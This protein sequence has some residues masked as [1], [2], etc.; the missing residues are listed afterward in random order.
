[1]AKLLE[2]GF[3][4]TANTEDFFDFNLDIVLEGDE[5]SDILCSFLGITTFNVSF[6]GSAKFDS[7]LALT[8]L[9]KS[10]VD[11]QV[12]IIP[13]GIDDDENFDY[14]PSREEYK[15]VIRFGE[16]FLELYCKIPVEIGE[17]N[18]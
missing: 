14:I 6:C 15:Y 12:I 3:T 4:I 13:G 11:Q 17:E 9:L 1:M 2:S 7:V 8:E 16:N 18:E 10:F 5:K